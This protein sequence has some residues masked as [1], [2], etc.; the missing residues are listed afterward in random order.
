MAL[1][2]AQRDVGWRQRKRP[3]LTLRAVALRQ[4]Q[5]DAGWGQRRRPPL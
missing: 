4:A 1:R 2:Q 5:R 3:P